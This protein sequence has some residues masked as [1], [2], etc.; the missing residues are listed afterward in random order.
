[1]LPAQSPLRLLLACLL[2]EYYCPRILL[3]G[4]VAQAPKAKVMNRKQFTEVWRSC[5]ST[6]GRGRLGRLSGAIGWHLSSEHC[7]WSVSG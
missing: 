3:F 1:M 4:L 5:Q 7:L 6:C 2:S